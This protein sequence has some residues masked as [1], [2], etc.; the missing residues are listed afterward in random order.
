MTAGIKAGK[1]FTETYVKVLLKKVKKHL[2][3]RMFFAI[4]APIHMFSLDG[5]FSVFCGQW[6]VS[7]MCRTAVCGVADIADVADLCWDLPEFAAYRQ[8]L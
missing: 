6:V 3:R 2:P 1:I 4:I 8:D 7:V 5:Y